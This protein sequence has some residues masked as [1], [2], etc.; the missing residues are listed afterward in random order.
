MRKFPEEQMMFRRYTGPNPPDSSEDSNAGISYWSFDPE[1]PRL[2]LTHTTSHEA[3]M[4]SEGLYLACT[5]WHNATSQPLQVLAWTQHCWSPRIPKDFPDNDLAMVFEFRYGPQSI[6]LETIV[7]LDTGINVCFADVTSGEDSTVKLLHGGL[8]YLYEPAAGN[9]PAIPNTAAW[10][11]LTVGCDMTVHHDHTDP[12]PIVSPRVRTLSLSVLAAQFLGACK[13]LPELGTR[14][15][16]FSEFRHMFLPAKSVRRTKAGSFGPHSKT[17]IA[18]GAAEKVSG[19]FH[20]LVFSMEL[21]CKDKHPR[22]SVVAAKAF[23]TKE[24]FVE[25][26]GTSSSDKV[27]TMFDV[28]LKKCGVHYGT[29]MAWHDCEKECKNDVIGIRKMYECDGQGFKEIKCP[30]LGIVLEGWN[31]QT[32]EYE[33]WENETGMWRYRMVRT[34][35]AGEANDWAGSA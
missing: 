32:A 3:P 35:L 26:D 16:V 1:V 9:I 18:F 22:V 15:P 17:L 25:L 2:T 28:A 27:D 11:T 24:G 6:Q 19:L 12:N 21:P 33:R 8:L 29:D 7:P 34:L 10:S 13:S 30:G 31:G 5:A 23:G 14:T 4:D 20:I